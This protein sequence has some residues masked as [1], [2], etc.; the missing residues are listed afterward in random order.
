MGI[1]VQEER[2]LVGA[3]YDSY[4]EVVVLRFMP[5]FPGDNYVTLTK[6]Q[7]VKLIG[8]L[9]HSAGLNEVTKSYDHGREEPLTEAE[10]AATP[11]ADLLTA[12]S[13]G[14]VEGRYE[15]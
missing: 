4:G 9:E 7:V 3:S 13:S 6:E 14:R 12:V 10:L 11:Y 15:Q 8:E 2:E 5:R 1:W